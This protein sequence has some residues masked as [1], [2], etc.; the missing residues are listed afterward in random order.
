MTDRK[1]SKS[2]KRG[3]HLF[4]YRSIDY[5]LTLPSTTA[6][7]TAKAPGHPAYSDANLHGRL[8][9]SPCGVIAL[10][11]IAFRHVASSGSSIGGCA[12]V[13]ERSDS[14]GEDPCVSRSANTTRWSLAPDR[15]DWLRQ[16]RLLWQDG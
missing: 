5:R 11:S 3:D 8:E 7:R 13:S 9:R 1:W 15:M 4:C 10:R 6:A 14:E 16:L 2:R 12:I